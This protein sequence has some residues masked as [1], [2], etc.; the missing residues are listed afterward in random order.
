MQEKLI[1]CYVFAIFHCLLCRQ[2]VVPFASI[3]PD[4]ISF[5]PCDERHPV[6]IIFPFGRMFAPRSTRVI[7]SLFFVLCSLFFVLCSL[8]CALCSVF[9]LITSLT[10]SVSCANHCKTDSN[11]TPNHTLTQRSPKHHP[12]ITQ[13]SIAFFDKNMP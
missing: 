12:R 5:V 11:I 7:R 9:Q 3:C 8:F 13:G 4:L 6:V 2:R 10:S 1:F